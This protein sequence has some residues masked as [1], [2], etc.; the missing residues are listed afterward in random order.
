[1]PL[2]IHYLQML[3]LQPDSSSYNHETSGKLHTIFS[4]ASCMNGN[5][6]IRLVISLDYHSL[7]LFFV[8]QM[9]T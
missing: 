2:Y 8:P 7:K 3:G 1:M 6:Y 9:K 4:I 5:Q